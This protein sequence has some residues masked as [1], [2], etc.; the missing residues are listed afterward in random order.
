MIFIRVRIELSPLS[1]AGAGKSVMASVVIADLEARADASRGRICLAYIYFRYSDA[2]ELTVRAVLEILVKQTIERHPECGALAE[3]TYARHLHER[4]QPTQSDLLQLLHRCT[5]VKAA[6]F[7][8]LDALDEAPERLR[9]D[10][11]RALASLNVKLFITSRPLKSVEAK[12]T[13]TQS[14]TI[15]AQDGDLDLHISQEIS[16]S[17]DLQDLLDGDPDFKQEVLSSIKNNCGGM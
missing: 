14:F 2:A 5:Q 13:D 6:T 17:E 10:V 1:V 7:Y 11:V 8:V 12:F 15:A 4:T 16:R 3:Q 9:V